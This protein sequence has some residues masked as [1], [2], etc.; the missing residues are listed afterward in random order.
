MR[1]LFF[2]LISVSALLPAQN[3]FEAYTLSKQR[4]VEKDT[5]G[6]FYLAEQA[7]TLAP[8]NLEISLNYARACVT[9][10]RHIR[11]SNLLQYIA[12]I[13]FDYSVESDSSFAPLW[14]QSRFKQIVSKAKEKSTLTASNFAFA[15]KEKDFIPGGIAYDLRQQKFYIGSMYKRKIVGVQ[16][17]GTV[18]DFIGESQDGLFSPQSIKIDAARNHLWVAGTLGTPRAK[19]MNENEAGRSAVFH[20]DLGNR[21]LIKKYILTDT[22]KHRFNDLVLSGGSV[23]VT[24]GESSTIY[25]INKEAQTIAPLYRWEWMLFPK[26]ITVSS[27]QKYLFVAHWAGIGRISLA[28]TQAMNL[29]VKP[30]TTLTGVDGLA[31]YENTLIAVQNAAGPQSRV[32]KFELSKQ[33]D[34]VIKATVLESQNPLYNIPTTG[35]IVDDEFYL[36]ANSQLKNFDAQGTIFPQEKLQ[37]TYILKLK[38]NN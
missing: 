30:T 37:P 4:L 10:G 9:M 31:F 23:Y 28:D 7:Y 5:A 26:G 6:Y 14:K 36:I 11:A 33:M 16:L 8:Y 29:Q 27:D 35:T 32:M 38:L 13:G 24:D 1:T 15:V 34:A 19:T 3:P 25:V 21:Q 17:D 12:D 2:L 20:F 18:F 22:V